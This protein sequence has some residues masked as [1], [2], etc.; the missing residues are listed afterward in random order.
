MQGRSCGL[1][2]CWQGGVVKAGT[3]LDEQG[4]NCK[5]LRRGQGG[6]HVQATVQHLRGQASPRSSKWVYKLSR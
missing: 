5:A 3:H 1:Y 4:S 6:C 2:L